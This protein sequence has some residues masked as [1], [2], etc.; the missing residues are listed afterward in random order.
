M[1]VDRLTAPRPPFRTPEAQRELD[2]RTSG[3]TLY[4]LEACPFCVKVRR[5][6]LRLGLNVRMRDIRRDEKAAAELI[7]GG[8]LDQAPCLRI[9]SSSGVQWMYESSVINEYLA[10]N[11]PN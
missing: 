2:A 3:L 8:K 10:K 5:E 11:F 9:E 7:A 4:Q 6:M 1:G